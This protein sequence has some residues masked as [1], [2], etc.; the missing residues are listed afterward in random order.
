V[1]PN[2]TVGQKKMNLRRPNEMLGGCM[3]LPRFIDKARH[4]LAGTLAVD[5]QRAFCSPL[6]IDGVFFSHFKLTK[7]EVI[8]AVE[9]EGSDEAVAEWFLRR[10]DSSEE[11]VAAWNALAP[12]IGKPGFPAHRTFAWGLKNI[13]IG[14]TDPRVDSGFTAI[15]WDEGFLDVPRPEEPNQTPE[16]TAPSGRGSA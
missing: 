8:A 13:Y 9:R 3:W 15:A 6:G 10:P 16:P 14:C 11:R 1:Q 5:F 4:H 2:N 7:E 12:N